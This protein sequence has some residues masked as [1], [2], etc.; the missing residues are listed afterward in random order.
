MRVR[1][2]GV[3]LGMAMFLLPA[4]IAAQEADRRPGVAVFPFEDGGW[5]GMATEDRGALSVGL[6]QLLLNELARNANL[7][8][9]ERNALREILAEIDLG[10]T[11][12]VDAGTAARVGRL[13]GA[14]YVVLGTFSDLGGSQPMLTGRVVS[15]ETSEVL[16]AEQVTGKREE[17]YAM[18]VNLS[19]EITNGIDLPPLPAAERET[20]QSRPVP[21]E[22]VRL[23]SRAQILQD[24]GRTEQAIE[25][26]EQ[27][28]REFPALTEA[29]EALKQLQG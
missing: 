7:R 4:A 13:V 28:S 25:L 16:E 27:I 18:V 12:R 8:I 3:M 17:L 24:L 2:H 22:A 11:G 29:Q 21:P 26:Y 20:R 6:Q 10:A 14:R 1:I 19:G 9:V 23:Y 5:T 15:V